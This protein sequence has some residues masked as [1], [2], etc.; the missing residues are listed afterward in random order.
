[1]R[2]PLLVLSAALALLGAPGCA[3]HSVQITTNVFELPEDEQPT[4]VVQGMGIYIH[5][6]GRTLAIA[7]P[8]VLDI[9][10]RTFGKDSTVAI[11][12][13]GMTYVC[14][15][16]QLSPEARKLL[17]EVTRG[18]VAGATGNPLGLLQGALNDDSNEKASGGA[19]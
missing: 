9:K 19:P 15:G 13:G 17:G 5:A 3:M 4:A 10:C 2:Q 6:A 18:A 7:G 8:V 11:E 1:M 12:W 14:E 16:G